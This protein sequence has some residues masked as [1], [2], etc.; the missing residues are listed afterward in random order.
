[1]SRQL[2]QMSISELAPLLRGREVSPVELTNSVFNRIKAFNKEINAYVEINEA[3][4]LESA[5]KAE[6][7]M[8]TGEY[9]GALHGI[10]LALKD[11]LHFKGENVA[12]G[13]KIHKDFIANEDATVVS[14]LKAAGVVFTGKLNMHEYAWGGTTNNPHFGPTRNP[15]NLE[16]IPGGSS[17][18]SGAAVAADLTIASLGTDTGGSIRMPAAACGI[19]GLKPTH[20][21]VSKSGCFPLSWSLDH[22]GPMTK[23]VEDAAILL[24]YI[25]GYDV[26]DPTTENLSVDK[27][28][29]YLNGDIKGKIIG[30]EEDYFFHNVDEKI[31]L[32][33]RK[34]IDQ[35]EAMGAKVE[36]VKIPSLKYAQYAAMMTCYGEG[37]TIHSRNIRERP[38]DYGEDVRLEMKLAQAISST[39]YLQAQQ[40]RNRLKREFAKVFEKVDVLV[41]PML[42]ILPPNI[43]DQ[44]A[45]KLGIFSSPANL[46]GL[47]AISIPCGFSEGLPVGM[48]II[49]PAFEEGKVLNFAYA[50]EKTNPLKGKKPLMQME[51]KNSI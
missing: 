23:T 47:P 45:N 10:P 17:G 37:G 44:T 24:E 26:N 46:T 34:A 28:T 50:F 22:I 41:A 12:F 2:A 43:G 18:G 3:Q 51:V 5:K 6:E 38:E 36:I 32:L 31:E 48:Q 42:P 20:G 27:Y 4:A 16:R 14:K 15:W 7:E 11:I 29:S 30:I 40:V 13:S 33:V 9:K 39:D 1:M 25:A 19:V 49:G 8:I 21:R 35:L